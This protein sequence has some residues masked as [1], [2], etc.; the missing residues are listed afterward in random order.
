VLSDAEARAL[1]AAIAAAATQTHNPGTPNLLAE[2]DQA[3]AALSEVTSNDLLTDVV[4]Q[5]LVEVA[6][7]HRAGTPYSRQLDNA[8]RRAHVLATTEVHPPTTRDAESPD[9]DH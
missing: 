5:L 8:L 7:C 3:R 2:L 4:E 9:A 6:A 1:T